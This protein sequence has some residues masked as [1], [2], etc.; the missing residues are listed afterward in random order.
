[1]YLEQNPDFY[2]P[3]EFERK[4][5]QVA[6]K[7]FTNALANENGQPLACCSAVNQRLVKRI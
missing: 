2:L 7:L 5:E 4:T 1:M 6:R 3:H